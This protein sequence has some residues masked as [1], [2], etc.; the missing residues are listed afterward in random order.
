MLRLVSIYEQTSDHITFLT[1]ELSNNVVAYVMF[2]T[3]TGVSINASNYTEDYPTWRCVAAETS[4]GSTEFR[5]TINNSTL[6]PATSKTIVDYTTL[7]PRLFK[8][9]TLQEYTI[10]NDVLIRFDLVR[11]RLPNPGI[12]IAST[13]GVG[14]DGVVAF[15]GGHEKKM[16]ISELMQMAEGAVVEV[17][18]TPPRT[19]FWPM[20]LDLEADK[21]YN[22][23]YSNAGIPND[24][25]ELIKMGTLIRCLI[26]MGILEVDISFSTSDSG[27]QLTFDRASHV[28]GWH[29]A[30]LTEY[31]EMKAL[32]K[33]NH[34]NHAGV[35]VGTVPFS[36]IGIWGTLMNNATVGG[37]L[38][39]NSVLG[40]TSR[41][42]VPM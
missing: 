20:Y 2:D 31:K 18:G 41:G 28:K 1:E 5:F 34:A 29:D 11:K 42:N 7:S 9:M 35:G 10:L 24:M 12:G 15:T 21:A 27:L 3:S 13:D 33:W 17:N 4:T 39:L 26:S 8:I 16:M 6:Y 38:G 19:Q 36:A 30:L 37:T 22:P 23:Y 25:M 40:M 14:E 32:F